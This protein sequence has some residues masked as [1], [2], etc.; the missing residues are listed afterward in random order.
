MEQYTY[1][2]G[3]YTGDVYAIHLVN[4]QVVGMSGALEANDYRLYPAQAFI[5]HTD[6]VI[7]E[8]MN[9]VAD[10]FHELD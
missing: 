7:I 3:K 2:Q 8:Y 10:W 6:G 5:R 9:K 4:G 1:W